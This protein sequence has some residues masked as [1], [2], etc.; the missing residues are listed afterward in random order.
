MRMATRSGP[1]SATDADVISVS[2]RRSPSWPAT[3]SNATPAARSAAASVCTS[4]CSEVGLTG[5]IGS[6]DHAAVRSLAP[7]A[8]TPG[9][10]RADAAPPLT[11]SGR[12]R[13]SPI[14]IGP[15]AEPRLNAGQLAPRLD[16]RCG[17]SSEYAKGLEPLIVSKSRT[18][19]GWTPHEVG[20]TVASTCRDNGRAGRT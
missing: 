6:A 15:P 11:A 1:T 18:I 5:R 10:A 3:A 9:I 2:Q 4:G 16:V 20:C 8:V 14:S 17:R 13:H 19:W 7:F 12:L